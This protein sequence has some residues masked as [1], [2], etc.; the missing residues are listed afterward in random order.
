MLPAKAPAVQQR[1]RAKPGFYCDGPAHESQPLQGPLGRDRMSVRRTV[2]HCTVM[3]SCQKSSREQLRQLRH[4]VGD[5]PCSVEVLTA[6]SGICWPST[7]SDMLFSRT[8]RPRERVRMGTS[9]ALGAVMRYAPSLLALWFS[10][11]TII[12]QVSQF[13]CRCSQSED[14]RSKLPDLAVAWGIKTLREFRM[15]RL[16]IM[17]SGPAQLQKRGFKAS[18]ACNKTPVWP[19]T[20]HSCKMGCRAGQTLHS[21]HLLWQRQHAWARG[22][23][24]GKGVSDCIR[25]PAEDFSCLHRQPGGH[26]R[27]PHALPLTRLGGSRSPRLLL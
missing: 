19:R 18:W 23:H 25:R 3:S 17:N 26:D 24:E 20:L 7:A 15:L 4:V 11:I 27:L 22:M 5:M 21:G 9:S 14:W 13:K 6:S 10:G 1:Y 16:W 8:M 2:S 12:L